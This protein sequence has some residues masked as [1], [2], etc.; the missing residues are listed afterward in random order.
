MVMGYFSLYLVHHLNDSRSERIIWLMELV[1]VDYQIRAY[2]R[3]PLTGLAPHSLRDVDG[4]GASP[5]LT[6]NDKT[7]SESGAICE[8]IVQ[9]TKAP[10]LGD[11]DSDEYIQIQF[12]SHFAEGSHWRIRY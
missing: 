12:W 4:I 5:I 9:Q 11:R 1:Q 10:L 2:R 8:Y 6:H 7:V 3:D